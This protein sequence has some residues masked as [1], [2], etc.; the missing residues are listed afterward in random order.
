MPLARSSRPVAI[1][2]TNLEVWAHR[3]C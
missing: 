3:S 1:Q 2:C